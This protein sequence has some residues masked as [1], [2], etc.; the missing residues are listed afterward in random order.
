MWLTLTFMT[1]VK[2]SRG[3][4]YL[5]IRECCFERLFISQ[6]NK[7]NIS[8]RI[9]FEFFFPIFN[10]ISKKARFDQAENL[11]ECHNYMLFV[12]CVKFS[13]FEPFKG[14]S[15]LVAASKKNLSDFSSEF[16]CRCFILIIFLYS[17]FF[18]FFYS[19][20]KR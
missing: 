13:A 18:L 12:R 17:F 11:I 8:L 5:I 15:F 20:G 10:L 16:F 2:L 3:K 19:V 4:L 7:Q 14:L 1:C 9:F 6:T